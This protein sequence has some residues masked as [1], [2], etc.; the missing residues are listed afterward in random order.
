MLWGLASKIRLA[1]ENRFARSRSWTEVAPSRQAGST[2]IVFA[3]GTLLTASPSLAH[4]SGVMFDQ[5]RRITLSGMVK[6]F[7]WTNPHC[8]IQVIADGAD[9]KTEWSVQM[10][11]PTELFRGGWRRGT[12]KAGDRIRV[13]IHPARGDVKAGM[14]V[15]ATRS[16]GEPLGKTAN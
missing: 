10:G 12:L 13:V 11:A 9:P 6:Q 2:W 14:F 7:Q 1:A 8:W 15:S 3:I 5:E 16:S 4:H